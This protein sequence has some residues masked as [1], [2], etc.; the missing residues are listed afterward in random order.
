MHADQI[1]LTVDVV[2]PLVTAQF[3]GWSGL[4]LAATAR[5]TLAALLV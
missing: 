1:D 2:G 5:H 4:P 3:P